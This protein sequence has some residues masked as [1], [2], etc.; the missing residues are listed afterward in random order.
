MDTAAPRLVATAADALGGLDGVLC[1][2]GAVAFGPLDETLI[3]VLQEIVAVD[4]V[5]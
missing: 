5:A 2:A 1:C 3:D 4:L